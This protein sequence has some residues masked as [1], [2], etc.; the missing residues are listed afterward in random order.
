MRALESERLRVFIVRVIIKLS[1]IT[2]SYKVPANQLLAECLDKIGAPIY[3][4]RQ[5]VNVTE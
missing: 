1:F 2:N 5:A 4:H 3:Y